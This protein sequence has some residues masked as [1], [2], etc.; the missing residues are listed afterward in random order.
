M[1]IAVFG[2]GGIGGYL[3]ARLAAAGEEVLLIARGPHLGVI[4]RDGLRVETPN[5][6]L[7]ATPALATDD[8]QE[9]GPVDMILLGVK[10]WDVR[11]AARAM[12]PMI[13]PGTAVVTLQNGVDAPTD[14]AEVLGPEHVIA[15]VAGVRSVAVAPGRIRH[16]GGVDPNLVIGEL[17]GKRGR[18]SSER[19]E[20]LRAALERA[21]VTVMV[22]P[23]IEAWLWGKLAAA[24]ALGGVG[25]VVRVPTG[26]WRQVP[27]ALGM[28]EQVANEVIAVARAR[29]VEP[30]AGV[31]DLLKA[32]VAAVPPDHRASLAEDVVEGRPS[33]LE[34][35]NGVVVRLG[36][37]AGVATPVND[38]I[39]ASLLPR[40][41]RVRGEL[42]FDV[43]S[44]SGSR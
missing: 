29:G 10:A 13:H 15:G 22:A 20:Q 25:A 44:R 12:R 1:R 33:E 31:V 24:A 37:Q 26:I 3:G 39:Y 11:A 4:R 36:R 16:L 17:V 34:Y 8:V 35:W 38:L 21:K 9:A 27:E 19:A 32:T 43:G 14:V 23:D 41:K 42:F 30:P 2:A 5:G 28:L 7:R 40:E 18:R 6:E